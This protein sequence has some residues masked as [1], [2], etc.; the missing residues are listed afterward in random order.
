[1]RSVDDRHKNCYK[2]VQTIASANIDA[3]FR[4]KSRSQCAN[5]PKLKVSS[6][7]SSSQKVRV[8][9]ESI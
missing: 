5:S 3:S 1:M 2:V 6:P 9:L 7:S 4:I 8:K